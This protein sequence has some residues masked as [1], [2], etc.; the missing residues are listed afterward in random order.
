L[1]RWDHSEPRLAS[2]HPV[3][4]TGDATSDR[5][6]GGVT[7]K[8]IHILENS[9]TTAIARRAYFPI[10]HGN[11]RNSSYCPL[12]DRSFPLRMPQPHHLLLRRSRSG[13][14]QRGLPF[15][16]AGVHRDTTDLHLEILKNY[17]NKLT[18]DEELSKSDEIAITK[19]ALMLG[20]ES[21]T[22]LLACQQIS[23]K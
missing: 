22:S 5:L 6:I 21:N 17:L 16:R 12:R 4:D 13:G 2:S 19:A 7:R 15:L 8:I 10:D 3:Y 23:N 9:P 14:H 20:L 11:Y 18:S 1:L